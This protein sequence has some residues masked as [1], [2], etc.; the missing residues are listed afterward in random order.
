MINSKADDVQY[1]IRP[2]GVVVEVTFSEQTKGCARSQRQMTSS[3]EQ[4]LTQD[5]QSNVAL[6]DAGSISGRS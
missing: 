6:S 1:L 4:G 2:L 5:D 3:N